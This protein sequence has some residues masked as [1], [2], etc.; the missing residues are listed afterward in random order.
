MFVLFIYF[1]FFW[2]N[3]VKL[4]KAFYLSYLKM[5]QKP[6]SAIT[7]GREPRSCLGRVFNFKLGCS[8]SEKCNCTA[9]TRP[10]L[11]LKIQPRF[12]PVS[13]S[14][15]MQRVKLDLACM[16]GLNSLTTRSGKQDKILTDFEIIG[17]CGKNRLLELGQK[18]RHQHM[19]RLAHISTLAAYACFEKRTLFRDIRNIPWK[20][21]FQWC[22]LRFA[23]RMF[24]IRFYCFRCG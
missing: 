12:C 3:P 18:E 10:L 7:N 15:S 16:Y 24:F 19:S 8:V 1:I 2:C 13:W 11:E 9:C 14:L 22:H 23:I 5:W 4:D 20:W 17:P 21:T 6:G